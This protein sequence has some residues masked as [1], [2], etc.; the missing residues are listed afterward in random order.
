MIQAKITAEVIYSLTFGIGSCDAIW[1][2]LQI[3][4]LTHWNKVYLKDKK[5]ILQQPGLSHLCENGLGQG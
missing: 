4:L 5:N 2:N 1:I 3:K